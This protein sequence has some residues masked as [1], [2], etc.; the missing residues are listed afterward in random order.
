[1]SHTAE[2]IAVGTEILLGNIANTDAQMLSEE[3]AAL[4][5]NVLYHTVVGDNPTRLAEAL[6]LARRRV[7]IVIT[8]GGLGP[9]YDDLTKQTI[10]TVVGRKNVFHPEIADALRT[11]FASIG[12]ELT[13]N[14]LQQAYL[15]EN[16]TIFRNHNGTAPGCGFCEG[17]VHVLMLPGPPHE[18]ADM[19]RRQVYDRLAARTGG[20]IAS[21]FIRIYGMGESQV[22]QECAQ[23]IENGEGVTVAPYCSLG[24]CQ[25]RVTARGRDE[26]EALRQVEPVVDAICGVLGDCVYDVTE[27]SD[28]SMQE[29]AGRALVARHLTV[30]TAESCTGG[31]VAASLVDYPGISECLY[32][33]HV[34][35]ANEAK[36]KY[37]GVKP[38]TLA[39]Y[40]AVSEQTAAEMAGGLREKSGADIAVATTGIA[41][42]GGGT[43]EKPVG[44]VYVACAD[45]DGVTVERLQLGGDR[46]RVRRLATLKALDMVR[47]AAVK[48]YF[49]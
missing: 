30:S 15:P 35:Y 26:A 9:T 46:A 12:R 2:L 43:K 3:L 25:L 1:M 8:T 38:E 27:T 11:H 32:E 21:R 34:T 29:A 16:C 45:K 41:G 22:A 17:G 4:G 37:C 31:M 10:C 28:G 48:R 23:W 7:D 18:M 14:N 20:C 44:L 33:A 24:E 5:V 47:R 39:A 13:E 40:G 19:F 49:E 36:V 42:P 6:E